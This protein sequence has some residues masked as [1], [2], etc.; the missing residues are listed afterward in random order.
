[1]SRKT[2]VALLCSAFLTLVFALLGNAGPPSHCAD[3]DNDGVCE[4]YSDNCLGV[5]NSSQRDDDEDGY[6]NLCDADVTQDCVIGGPD[7]AAVF[8]RVLDGAPWTPKN[9]GAYDVN[10]DNVVGG[11]DIAIVF[12]EA[13]D[14]PGPSALNCA[15]C[16]ALPTAGLG[17]GVCPSYS[18]P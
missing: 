2:I 17:L 11:P 1:M 18:Y 6:G 10:Q 7:I 16:S 15:D 3:L 12:G 13:L 4:D 8:A 14:L 9:A 5:A